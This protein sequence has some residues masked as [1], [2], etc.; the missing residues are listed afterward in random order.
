MAKRK[1]QYDP[2]KDNPLLGEAA[3]LIVG[4]VAGVAGVGY[5][6]YKMG[7]S[8]PAL[9]PAPTPTPAASLRCLEPRLQLPQQTRPLA[10]RSL[11]LRLDRR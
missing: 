2:A 3:L 7:Q 8:A 1:R 5:L 4:A 9:T 6:A 11:R 10:Y